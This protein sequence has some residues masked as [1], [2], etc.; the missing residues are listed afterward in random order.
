MVK[1]I[2]CSLKKNRR[3]K[4]CLRDVG[5]AIFSIIIPK[6]DNSNNKINQRSIKKYI[7]RMNSRFGGT[8]TKPITLGCWTDE[9]RKKLQCEV[10]MKVSVY[11][12]WDSTSRKDLRKLDVQQREARLKSDYNFMKRVAKD[13]ANE[14]GQD[15]IPVIYDNVRD[16]A[17]VKGAVKKKLNKKLL[18]GKKTPKDPFKKHI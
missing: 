14:F 4:K 9:K 18:S 6:G 16:I 11:V 13:M 2:D 15:T 17:F 12:D 8:T 7:N 1:R 10:G 3:N 5:E